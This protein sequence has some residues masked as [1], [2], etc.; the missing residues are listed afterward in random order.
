MLTVTQLARHCG[1]SRSTVLYYER[2]GL[3]SPT[4]RSDNGYRWYG[5]T[6][7]QRCQTIARYRAFGLSL[8]SIKDLLHSQEGSSQSRILKTHF[9][10]LENEIHHLREQQKAII[11]LLRDTDLQE[12]TMVTKQRWVEI[13]KAAGFDEAAMRRWHQKFEEM[14]PEEHQKFL[15]SLG[16]EEEE[17]KR[18]RAF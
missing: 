18:I 10:K 16:I 12:N 9:D 3:L 17:I 7:I 4:T 15:E 11:A 5:E 6:A 2:Q 8:A 1:L 14:E 13:M